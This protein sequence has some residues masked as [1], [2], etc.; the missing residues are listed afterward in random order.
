MITS[1]SGYCAGWLLP[2]ATIAFG[3]LMVEA[4][5]I[6][7]G[8][9]IGAGQPTFTIAEMSGNRNG[10]VDWSLRLLDAAKAAGA[11]AV[12]CRPTVPTLS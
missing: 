9:R 6:I 10:S 5:V 1:A 3:N 8:R 11:D 12:S 4:S 2:F 7:D